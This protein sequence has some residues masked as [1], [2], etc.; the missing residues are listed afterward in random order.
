MAKIEYAV[1]V[2]DLSGTSLLPGVCGPA[3][4]GRAVAGIGWP[5]RLRRA[6]RAEGAWPRATR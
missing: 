1:D 6:S 4:Y 2:W 3:G 5:P